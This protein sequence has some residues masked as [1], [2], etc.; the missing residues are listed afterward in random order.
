VKVE[1]RK[2]PVTQEVVIKAVRP[3]KEEGKKAMSRKGQKMV[4][5]MANQDPE[6]LFQ[7]QLQEN[8]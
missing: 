2:G 8:Q 7:H 1:A 3:L 5:K 6:E 4:V